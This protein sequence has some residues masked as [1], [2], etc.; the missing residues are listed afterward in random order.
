MRRLGA[1]LN[2][3]STLRTLILV[4]ALATAAWGGPIQAAASA[5]NAALLGQ[6]GGAVQAVATQGHWAFVG[7]GPRVLIMDIS[8]PANP[9]LV[10]ASQTFD[11][12]VRGI[13]VVGNVAYVAAG[14]AGLHMLNVTLPANPQP[15]G[16]VDTPGTAWRV[17]VVGA[18]AYVADGTAGLGVYQIDDP[19]SPIPRAY[20]DTDHVARDVVVRD[21][22]AYVA[23]TPA[24][25]QGGR[26]YTVDVTDP[27]LLLPMDAYDSP[28][29]ARAIDYWDDL[30]FV[31]D[32]SGLR[33]LDA[34]DPA[35]IQPLSYMATAGWTQDVMVS[36]DLDTES[37]YVLMPAWAPGTHFIDVTDPE[38][39]A[40]VATLDTNGHSQDAALTGS[41]ALIAAENGLRLYDLSDPMAPAMPGGPAVLGSTPI[42]GEGL[43]G[44]LRGDWA[45]ATEAPRFDF[46]IGESVGGGLRSY[47][48]SSGQP[49]E[50]DFFPTTAAAQSVALSGSHA[51]V[52]TED[53]L[54]AVDIGDPATLQE[55]GRISITGQSLVISGSYAYIADQLGLMRV[56]HI[57]NPAAMS[58]LAQVDLGYSAW[59]I[60]VNGSTVFVAAGNG[61]LFSYDVSTPASPQPLDT[62]D[63]PGWANDLVLVGDYAMV[64]ALNGDL[65]VV[66]VSDP[67]NMALVT[68]LPLSGAPRRIERAGDFVLIAAQSGHL[69]V[70]DVHLPTQPTLAATLTLTS[71]L[72]GVGVDGDRAVL[73]AFDDLVL[74]DV[75][76]PGVV[77]MAPV[78]VAGRS[79]A[80]VVVGDYAF[81]A[82]RDNGLHIVNVADPMAPQLVSTYAVPG[83]CQGIAVANGMAYLA[84]GNGLYIVDVTEPLA[85]AMAGTV[86]TTGR[87]QDVALF[88]QYALLANIPVGLGQDAGGGLH[89]IDVSNPA[90]PTEINYTDTWWAEG[91]QAWSQAGRSY[92]L[93]ASGSDGLKVVD[94]T[95]VNNLTELDALAVGWASDVA[96]NANTAFVVQGTG[97]SA[98]DLTTPGDLQLVANLTTPGLAS[99]IAL[100][101]DHAYIA[102]GNR[103]LTVA[104]VQDPAGMRVTATYDSPGTAQGVSV[105][106]STAWLADDHGGLV[107][108]RAYADVIALPLL[109][110]NG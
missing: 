98:I 100:Q 80:A 61:G 107:G 46:D 99:G 102:D 77:E 71:D 9:L 109:L 68:E 91:V 92:A 96:A 16:E 5:H 82:A 78:S 25:G 105:S 39:P 67:S 89:I 36:T 1:A 76:Y 41:T 83:D 84:N 73:A 33:I 49:I 65:Q 21:Q 93:L 15:L 87:S 10:G 19:T 60:A 47:D 97:I 8:E 56:V 26:I 106:G 85:P 18:Y 30:I 42:V 6:V 75:T 34:S 104:E 29:E 64:A 37:A 70:I 44:A 35:E 88:G 4:I 45:F 28:G 43:D 3:L 57:A 23:D 50:D 62:L 51:F 53:A 13:T 94:I 27:S 81:V 54:H 63:I 95:D 11:D 20:F 12:L 79:Q 66:D 86:G 22:V 58:Q 55:T 52:I 7:V 32:G 31:A 2:R 69:Q 40:L 17:D 110:R 24:W 101:G 72:M 90:A 48:V 59:G 74:A 38:A 108:I 103:G 14:T